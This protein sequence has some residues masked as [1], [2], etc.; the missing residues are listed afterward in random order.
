MTQKALTVR[1]P[2]E[3]FSAM[4][5]AAERQKTTVADAVRA[6]CAASAS[7]V[8][9]NDIAAAVARLEKRLDGLVAETA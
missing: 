5:Q 1:M 7:G 9:L 6:A 8:S 2:D 4:E 3:L